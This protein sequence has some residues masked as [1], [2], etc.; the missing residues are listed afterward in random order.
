MT[1][2][3]VGIIERDML[4]AASSDELLDRLQKIRREGL[5]GFVVRASGLLDI[6]VDTHEGIA[7]KVAETLYA[8]PDLGWHPTG[9]MTKLLLAGSSKGYGNWH[10]DA[11]LHRDLEFRIQTAIHGMGKV[12]LGNA[13]VPVADYIR[14]EDDIESLFLWNQVDPLLVSPDVYTTDVNTGDFVVFPTALPPN[15]LNRVQGPVPHRFDTSSPTRQG[16]V[17]AIRLAV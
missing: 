9:A 10:H 12:W 4:E 15:D 1:A 7:A 11:G 3:P 16:E 5:P 17:L 14:R 2:E 13:L 6:G 8:N